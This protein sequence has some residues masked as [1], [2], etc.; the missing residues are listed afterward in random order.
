MTTDSHFYHVFHQMK[1]RCNNPKDRAYKNYGGRGI[2]NLWVSFKTF[3][4]DMYEPYLDH[5]K[6]YGRRQTTLD[7]INNNGPYCVENCEWVTPKT[8]GGNKRTNIYV[9]YKNRRRL[10]ADWSEITRIKMTT[11]W[12]R[13]FK[14][15]WPIEKAMTKTPKMTHTRVRSLN[16]KDPACA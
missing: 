4:S 1:Q 3:E 12:M 14:Y 5:C 11:L 7:R 6:E 16:K 10:L 15:K 13:I 9:T 2:K 8:Q